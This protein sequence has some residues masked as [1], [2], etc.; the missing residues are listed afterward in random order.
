MAG[1]VS[2]GK[3]RG[4]PLDDTRVVSTDYPAMLNCFSLDP[5]DLAGAIPL[6]H[7]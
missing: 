6:L 1:L 4:I 3:S 7:K 5:A 2:R